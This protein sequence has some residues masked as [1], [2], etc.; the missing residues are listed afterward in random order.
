MRSSCADAAIIN[1]IFD[2]IA[3]HT[4]PTKEKH[5]GAEFDWKWSI[6][7]CTS[8]YSKW[9]IYVWK[10]WNYHRNSLCS[11]R[12]RLKFWIVRLP[13]G[14]K[15]NQC[16][17]TSAYWKFAM[18]VANAI[19]MPTSLVTYRE[20]APLILPCMS[21]MKMH[22]NI[23]THMHHLLHCAPINWTGKEMDSAQFSH[24]DARIQCNCK[25][26]V[27]PVAVHS[28]IFCALCA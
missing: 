21:S 23:Y 24:C 18:H 2:E 16:T 11:E 27:W 4:E 28:L 19:K 1:L 26:F 14:I 17:H 3:M 15:A 8:I 6:N 5:F 9:I 13:R 22:F 25:M 12:E 20:F 7:A 10:R